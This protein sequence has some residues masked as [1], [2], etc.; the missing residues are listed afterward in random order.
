MSN[1]L[2]F[3]LIMSVLSDQIINAVFGKLEK[4]YRLALDINHVTY[5]SIL[6]A[7]FF[8]PSRTWHCVYQIN[9]K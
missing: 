7:S 9:S 3:Y 8:T 5:M 4:M 1:T 6:V 2:L